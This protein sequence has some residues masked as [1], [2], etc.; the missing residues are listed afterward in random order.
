VR[1]ALISPLLPVKL[2]VSCERKWPHSS[3]M[4]QLCRMRRNEVTELSRVTDSHNVF[5]QLNI[6]LLTG[7]L[8]SCVLPGSVAATFPV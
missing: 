8:R 2:E 1:A 4:I 7:P 5:V 6:V 3:D